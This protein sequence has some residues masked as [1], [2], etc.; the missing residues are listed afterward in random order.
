MRLT[1][2]NI[3][4]NGGVF[5]NMTPEI[6]KRYTDIGFTV[7]GLMCDLNAT[8]DDIR[9]IK[10]LWAE[11]G[12]EFGPIGS[13]NDAIFFHPDPNVARKGK[14]YFKKVL[15]I[16]GKLGCETVRYAAG[17]MDPKG[18]WNTHW[19]NFSQE[20]MDKFVA[21]TKELVP[22]A[23]DNRVTLCPETTHG[24]IV[25]NI[26]RMKEYVDRLDSPY[27]KIIFDPVNQTT[28]DNIYDNGRF[29][30]C[31]IAELGGR[32]G[33]IHCKDVHLT[34]NK[35]LVSHIDETP[36]GTGVL[37]HAAVLQASTQLEPWKYFCLEHI[38]SLAGIKSA[39]DHIMQDARDIGHQWTPAGCTRAKWEQSRR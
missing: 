32:I 15:E 9:Y 33:V 27:A 5:R 10:D 24:L 21:A 18:R 6:L 7:A 29:I 26:R 31:A 38:N 4:D 39:Y 1:W 19:D 2:I 25:N 35:V 36:M 22:Y 11:A 3:N 13:G 34:P 20:S 8:D 12:L 14:E 28:M 16:G 37:D 17:S 30:R 23:E